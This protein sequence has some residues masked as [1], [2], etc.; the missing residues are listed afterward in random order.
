M[1]FV[2]YVIE[3]F[4]DMILMD[5]ELRPESLGVKNDDVYRVAIGEDNRIIFV[6]VDTKE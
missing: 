6:K 1:I 4:N 5:K 2:D 3:K